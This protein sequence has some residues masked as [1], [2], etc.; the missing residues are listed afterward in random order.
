[1]STGDPI[2]VHG[3]YLCH[4]GTCRNWMELGKNPIEEIYKINQSIYCGNINKIGYDPE[5]NKIS[6]MN[7]V[8]SFLVQKMVPD[9]LLDDY[10]YNFFDE[11][12][13]KTAVI[14]LRKQFLNLSL[15][16]KRQVLKDICMFCLEES[17]GPCYCERDD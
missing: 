1:M 10:F 2:C 11:E 9:P 6:E 14:Q 8:D 5:Q 4:C 3:I 17:R 7:A 15:D 16:Q 12:N 13:Q